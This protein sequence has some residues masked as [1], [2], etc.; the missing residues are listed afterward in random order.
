MKLLKVLITL[1]AMIIF[2]KIIIEI[3]KFIIHKFMIYFPP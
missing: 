1:F 3:T 2:L